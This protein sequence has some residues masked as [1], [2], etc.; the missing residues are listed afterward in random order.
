MDLCSQRGKYLLLS[1]DGDPIVLAH[2]SLVTRSQ[3]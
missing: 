3:D 1:D 2:E